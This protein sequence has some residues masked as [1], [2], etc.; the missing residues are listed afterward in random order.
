VNLNIISCMWLAGSYHLYLASS[1]PNLHFPLNLDLFSI[2][3][4]WFFGSK[5]SQINS[6]E[7]C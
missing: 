5:A 6:E 7:P 1:F 2:Y 3:N 4:F